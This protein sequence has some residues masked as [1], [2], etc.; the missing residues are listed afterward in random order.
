MGPSNM[1][2]P[3]DVMDREGKK[4]WLAVAQVSS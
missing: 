2:D 3:L 1:I 4:M